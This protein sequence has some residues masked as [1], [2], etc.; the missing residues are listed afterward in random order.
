MAEATPAMQAQMKDHLRYLQVCVGWTGDECRQLAT[1][2]K[3]A[4]QCRA[5]FEIIEAHL[6]SVVPGEQAAL[7][8]RE[9]KAA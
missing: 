5:G 6:A 3:D 2:Y 9:R 8:R 7:M 1:D 4:M